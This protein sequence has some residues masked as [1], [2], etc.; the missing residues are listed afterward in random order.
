M[1]YYRHQ[2]LPYQQKHLNIIDC[3]LKL[4]QKL[5]KPADSH[6]SLAEYY[7]LLGLTHEAIKQLQI[8]LKT[9]K[10]DFYLTSR[11]EARLK[12][13]KNELHLLNPN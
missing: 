3:F 10:I 9:P 4:R 8:S 13:F 7:Y 2:I 6:Q 1:K 12:E 5:N 11:L